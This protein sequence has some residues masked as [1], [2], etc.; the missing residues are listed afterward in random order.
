MYWFSY[1]SVTSLALTGPEIYPIL[2]WSRVHQQV[3]HPNQVMFRSAP[4]GY[5]RLDL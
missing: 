1:M 4:G 5:L 3:T 2:H